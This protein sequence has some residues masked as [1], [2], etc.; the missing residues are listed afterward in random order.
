MKRVLGLLAL[1]LGGAGFLVCLAG[2]IALW[3]V[4]A[5]T[6]RRS[7]EALAS[8]EESLKV[9][10]EK[11][12]RAA[13]V[14]AKIRE[15]VDP[16][17]SKIRD[18]AARVQQPHP[19]DDKDL[20]R[21]EKELAQRFTKMESLVK[22]S[23]TAVG[24]MNKTARLTRSFSFGAASDGARESPREDLPDSSKVLLRL[25]GALKK[26]R[27]TLAEIRAN[28]QV[29]KDAAKE[30]AGLAREVNQELNLLDSQVQRARQLAT[31]FAAEVA[32]L[33]TAFPVWMNWATAIGS[34]FLVWM[35]LG[36]L[37]LLGLGWT[38]IRKEGGLSRPV[39]G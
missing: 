14:L 15:V 20:K 17:T 39:G 29:R 35:G 31:D 4:R 2:L 8:A 12:Q 3:V 37:A 27:G 16:V 28:P 32:E 22:I 36:Q 18:L 24:M 1:V 10:D 26:L 7:G 34:V 11:A 25:S 38:W 23:E 13:E 5:P 9:V 6:L 19:E 30:V 21:I 33:Q